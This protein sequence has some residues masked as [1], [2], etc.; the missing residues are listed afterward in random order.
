MSR[1]GFFRSL[2]GL[3]VGVAVAGVPAVAQPE[4]VK[5]KRKRPAI[6]HIIA[7]TAEPLLTG[8][9]VLLIERNDQWEAI[10]AHLE[11]PD[12]HALHDVRHALYLEE[13][14]TQ[15]IQQF[16]CVAIA[17]RPV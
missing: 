4:P 6:R 15:H 1:R 7:K 17:V 8:Q 9:P 5:A 10:A 13:A 2:G 14:Q 3:G 11:E 12:G 16:L